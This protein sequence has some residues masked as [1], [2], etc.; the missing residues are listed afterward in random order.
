[1]GPQASSIAFEV[2]LLFWTI[3]ALAVFFTTIVAIGI[4]WF[5]IRYRRRSEDEVPVQI[6]GSIRLELTWTI[7]PLILGLG[8]FVWGALI[9]VR[10]NRPPTDTLDI[11]VIGRQ[12]MWKVQH[13]TG[14][15]E[16]D[17]L[18]V[19]IGRPVKLIMTSQDV[20][21]DVG[22][23]AFRVKQDVLPGRYTEMW[24]TPT[25]AGVYALN[26]SEYCGTGHSKMVGKVYAMPEAEY[27]AWLAGV[28]AGE[29][30]AAAG[31]RLFS[32]QGCVGCHQAD[33]QGRGPN[34][35]G[36]FGSQVELQG[37][38]TVLADENYIRESILNPRAKIVAGHQPIMPTFAGQLSDEQILQLIAY[39]QSIGG[40]QSSGGASAPADSSQ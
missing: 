4:M 19:P 31:L 2:D 6:E 33:G 25:R 7:I 20:I 38:A 35:A 12:W 22:I 1:M 27:E 10:M 28:T 3:T 32:N 30:P 9:F 5:A 15:W 34:L 39:I 14:Q 24:F 17:E 37:G 11:Y 21:H 8:V 18:H 40:D 13:P 23:P 26:C 16:N 29:S 36:V